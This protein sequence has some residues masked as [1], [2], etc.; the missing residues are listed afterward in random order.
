MDQNIMPLKK[1]YIPNY[2]TCVCVYKAQSGYSRQYSNLVTV[3]TYFRSM[4]KLAKAG[5]DMC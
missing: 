4:Q 2:Y 3:H 5:S 1:I